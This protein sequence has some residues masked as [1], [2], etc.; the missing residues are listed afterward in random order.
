VLPA[1]KLII[2]LCTRTVSWYPR[3][4]E[5]TVSEGLPSE[6]L[7]DRQRSF[8]RLRPLDVGLVKRT[9]VRHAARHLEKVLG[10]RGP[11]QGS[12]K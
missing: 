2:I 4:R 3:R 12:P 5:V 9:T 6:A 1:L 10:P 11:W 8:Q 7:P